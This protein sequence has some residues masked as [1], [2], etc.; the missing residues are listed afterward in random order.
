MPCAVPDCDPEG[1][2]FMLRFPRSAF[3]YDRWRSAIELGSGLP[4]PEDLDPLEAEICQQH[5][6]EVDEYSEPVIF[7]NQSVNEEIHLSSCRLC[8]RFDLASRVVPWSEQHMIGDVAVEEVLKETF[9][10]K[11]IDADFPE[12]ICEE[13]LVRLDMVVALRKQLSQNAKSWRRMTVFVN[14]ENRLRYKKKSKT[15]RKVEPQK[16]KLIEKVANE[17][18][19]LCTKSEP[20]VDL[21]TILEDDEEDQEQQAEQEIVVDNEVEIH[22]N[23]DVEEAVVE[24]DVKLVQDEMVKI[25]HNISKIPIKRRQIGRPKN[26]KQVEVKAKQSLKGLMERKCY[27]CITLFKTSEEL[28]THMIEHIDHRLDCVTCGETFPNLTKYNRH[29]AKHDVSERPFKCDRCELRFTDSLG[30][31]RHEKQK[32]SIEHPISTLRYDKKKKGKYTCQHCGKQCLSMSFLREHEDAHAGIKRHACQICGRLFANKNNLERHHLIH[33]S[34]KPYKCNICGKAFRQSPM[35]KDH[36]RLHSGEKPYSC[37]ACDQRFSSTP[38]LRKHKIKYHSENSL[39]K[40]AS[41]CQPRANNVCQFCEASFTR[42]L[43]LIDHIVAMHPSEHVQYL[44][45]EI[46]DQRFLSKNILEVHIRNH[47]KTQQCEFC[48]KAFSTTQALKVHQ[49]IH[50]GV[51]SHTCKTCDK[52]FT[53]VA[54][55]KRHE[56]LHL[57]IKR[58]ECDFCGKKFAQS[59]QLHTHRRTHTGE[60]PYA[61]EKC[62][63]RFADNSTLCKHRKGVCKKV[64]DKAGS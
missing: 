44:T 18:K 26:K 58:H 39:L 55:L 46:C 22:H 43:L 27:M 20:A 40:P 3:L 17:I 9:K 15:D 61:C 32:H 41:Q 8:L 60:K 24:I 42:H 16:P 59:N 2:S 7:R 56:L 12:G 1:Q 54:N 4:F 31:R 30:K 38:L 63:K 36:M 34:E 6:D 50:G 57:G 37:T 29:I 25:E 11:L 23:E 5:F 47:E 19:D 48:D 51:R 13:C 35:Y 45:C 28:F 62:G 33:T 64:D 14:E 49:A 10:I 53:H 21:V 52:S